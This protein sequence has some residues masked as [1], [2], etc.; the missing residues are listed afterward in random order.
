MKWSSINKF[1]KL[2]WEQKWIERKCQESAAK[3]QQRCCRRV[4]TRLNIFA[5]FWESCAVHTHTP[6]RNTH[7]QDLRLRSPTFEPVFWPLTIDHRPPCRPPLFTFGNADCSS[8]C[9]KCNCKGS[10]KKR[11]GCARKRHK[12]T[13]LAKR[14]QSGAVQQPP[15]VRVKLEI[16]KFGVSFVH[17]YLCICIYIWCICVRPF[18]SCSSAAA[19]IVSAAS[20]ADPAARHT[21][22]SISDCR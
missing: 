10:C 21:G 12:P 18:C 6:V 14:V 11:K 3:N 4:E 1:S 15:G 8:R 2:I 13:K 19:K 9:K 20:A 5:Y 22:A 16:R 7:T 17:L